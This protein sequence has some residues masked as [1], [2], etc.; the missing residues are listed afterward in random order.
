MSFGEK[1]FTLRKEKGLSQEALAEKLNTSR[2][3]ISKWENDQGYPETEKLLIIG[4]I[5]NVSIDYLLKGNVQMN[6]KGNGGYYVSKEFAEG[7]LINQQ[8]MGKY[9]G[10]GLFLIALSIV[11]YFFFKQEP[12]LYLIPTIIL[13]TIGIGTCIS[14][15][16][17]EENR[18][19]ILKQ[20]SLQFDDTYLRELTVR[21]ETVKKRYGIVMVFGICLFTSGIITFGIERNYL[22][23]YSLEDYHALVVCMIAIGLYVLCILPPFLS[24]INC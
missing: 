1:L 21:Y 4:N 6:K 8:K 17:L 18:Y 12:S 5:F 10:L 11:P 24:H 13:A 2:Q 9:I 22:S 19:K 23:S 7:Y 15:G 20:E 3:A 16:F 14:T